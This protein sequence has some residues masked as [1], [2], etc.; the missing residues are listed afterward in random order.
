MYHDHSLEQMKIKT[1]ASDMKQIGGQGSHT[2]NSTHTK[3]NLTITIPNKSNHW[4]SKVESAK[5]KGK[6]PL[7]CMMKL[8]FI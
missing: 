5:L 3:S 4:I 1:I 8:K 2:K 7:M 6:S